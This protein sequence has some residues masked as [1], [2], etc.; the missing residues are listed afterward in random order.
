M[1]T[2]GAD[3]GML[4]LFVFGE[5]EMATTED[6]A[7]AYASLLTQTSSTEEIV[8]VLESR[9]SPDLISKILNANAPRH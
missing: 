1:R 2:F 7:R 6:R 3:V 5:D 4:S 8:R 9:T